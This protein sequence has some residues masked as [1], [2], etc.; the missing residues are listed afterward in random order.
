MKKKF[1]LTIVMC[2]VLWGNVVCNAG[3][4]SLSGKVT[5]SV[6]TGKFVYGNGNNSL[7]IKINYS[8]IHST[9]KQIY[10]SRKS[11]NYSGGGNS[12][13]VTKYADT[14]YMMQFADFEGLCNGKS[15]AKIGKIYP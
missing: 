4:A 2:T 3:S 8:E 6:A 12:V 5:T 10:T 7:T 15:V 14:G 1:F 9:T 13:S 11:K